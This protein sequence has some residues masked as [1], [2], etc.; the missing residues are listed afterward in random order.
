MAKL[1]QK[2]YLLEVQK[3]KS[4]TKEL[5]TQLEIRQ[6]QVKRFKSMLSRKVISQN[7]YD[8]ELILL[9]KNQSDYVRS[10]ILL[11]KADIQLQ[12]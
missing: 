8:S 7:Q 4:D 2:R 11:E 9:S 1:D 5:L 3:L 12:F 6:R 10:K